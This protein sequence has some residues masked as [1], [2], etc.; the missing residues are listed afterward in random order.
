MISNALFGNL[1]Y[2]GI[3]HVIVSILFVVHK[4]RAS[5]FI[6]F[7]SVVKEFDRKYRVLLRISTK[8]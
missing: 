1:P 6:I 8:D 3:Q 4:Y 7:Q 5:V 2:A